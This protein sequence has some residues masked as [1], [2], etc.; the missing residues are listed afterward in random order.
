MLFADV[1]VNQKNDYFDIHPNQ[2]RGAP[3]D[4]LQLLRRPS[5]YTMRCL[6]YPPPDTAS[7]AVRKRLDE[8]SK[9]LGKNLLVGKDLD[10]LSK[11]LSTRDP[12]K[13]S[14]TRD[15]VAKNTLLQTDYAVAAYLRTQVPFNS[16][17]KLKDVDKATMGLAMDF[18]T[19]PFFGTYHGFSARGGYQLDTSKS[20]EAF[21]SELIYYPPAG[22]LR[23]I[24]LGERTEVGGPG[25]FWFVF[26]ATPRLRYGNIYENKTIVTLPPSGEFMRVGYKLAATLGPNGDDFLSKFGI[27]AAYLH[28]DNTRGGNGISQ[29]EKFDT[30]LNYKIT[31]NYGISLTYSK[32]RDED[33]LKPVNQVIGAVTIKFGEKP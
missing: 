14:I 21:T 25:G 16:N 29:F 5:N 24:Q 7:S 13:F 10:S 9:A 19:I 3:V 23:I 18:W 12:A 2:N 1:Y 22:L 11:S 32:G 4:M 27:S 6:N 30:S 8:V 31:D 17:N 15:G 26:E 28:F 33:Q 20:Y